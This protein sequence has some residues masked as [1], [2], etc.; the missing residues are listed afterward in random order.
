V[1]EELLDEQD[2]SDESQSEELVP[3]EVV[4]LELESEPVHMSAYM[5]M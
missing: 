2:Y 1:L 3:L 5:F 4:A